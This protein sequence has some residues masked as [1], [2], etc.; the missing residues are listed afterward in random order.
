MRRG[1]KHFRFSAEVKGR[2]RIDLTGYGKSTLQTV[3]SAWWLSLITPAFLFSACSVAPLKEKHVVQIYIREAEKTTP[4]TLDLF[5]FEDGGMMKLDSYER[6]EKWDGLP[7]NGTS[8]T[9]GRLLV[10]IANYGEDRFSWSDI[11][12]YEGLGVKTMELMEESPS[13]PVMS[14]ETVTL[15]GRDRGCEI[16]LSPLLARIRVNSICADFHGRPYEGEALKDVR[17]FL[18]NVH[19]RCKILSRESEPSWANYRERVYEDSLIYCESGISVDVSVVFP[20]VVLYCYP[21]EITEETP[22][23]PFTRLVIE[24]TIEGE[25]YYYPINIP[26]L[27]GGK[28]YAYNIT[29]TRKGTSDPDTSANVGMVRFN[30]NV[31]PWNDTDEKIERF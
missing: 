2:F 21:N 15:A 27:E 20:K 13:H 19:D 11:L 7:L 12:S 1:K 22:E 29:I 6:I 26:N 3:C 28:E 14:G 18:M 24:G 5:F 9:G 25:T 16:G 23:N 8:G 4:H 17:V 31:L 30:Q 10:A